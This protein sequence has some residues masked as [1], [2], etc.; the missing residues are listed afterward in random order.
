[1]DAETVNQLLEINRLF[2][3]QFS[4][5]FSDSR[6]SD[7]L[8]IEPFRS[9]LAN[10]IRLLDVGCGNGRLAETLERSGYA[11]DYL[12]IE[13]SVQLIEDASH[14]CRR[15]DNVH[16]EFLAVNIAEPG[17]GEGVRGVLA[18]DVI[19]ALAV[20]HHI[21]SFERRA[22][23]LQEIRKA[24]KPNGVYVMSNWQF[25]NSER[26]RNKIVGWDCVG[27]E[28]AR[29]ETGDY[30]LDWKRGGVGYRYVHL[31]DAPQVRELA[32][33]SGFLIVEQF[34]SDND[35]N[36]FSVLQNSNL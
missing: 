30:L 9:Y 2:Y 5:E 36:L 27:L 12:G 25:M 31:L 29:L 28:E 6:S 4:E 3:S 34:H 20:L 15:L 23:V 22:A 7:R 1:V 21:P 11:L 32:R 19:V 33:A 14:R 10:G 18:F 17:W 16:A 35:L 26:L 8:N 13:Q 24:L